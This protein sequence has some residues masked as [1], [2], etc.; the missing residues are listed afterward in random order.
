MPCTCAVCT[1]DVPPYEMTGEQLQGVFAAHGPR[2]EY[3]ALRAALKSSL[4]KSDALTPRE[5]ALER[6][7]AEAAAA[8]AAKKSRTDNR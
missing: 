1:T 8:L 7:A 4:R 2:V 6:V 5:E 3:E